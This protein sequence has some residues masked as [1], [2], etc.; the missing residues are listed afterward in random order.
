M[1]IHDRSVTA[2]EVVEPSSCQYPT[3]TMSTFVIESCVTPSNHQVTFESVKMDTQSQPVCSCEILASLTTEYNNGATIAQLTQTPSPL[4]QSCDV[5]L[6]VAIVP[7]IVLLIVLAGIILLWILVVNFK[8]CCKRYE[9]WNIHAS[10][11]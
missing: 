7:T 5:Q 1:L 8:R 11:S 9:A 10:T 2:V 4:E 6:V 3:P